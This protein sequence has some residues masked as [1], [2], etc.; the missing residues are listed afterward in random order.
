MVQTRR[1]VRKIMSINNL[2]ST[3]HT[4]SSG[5]CSSVGIATGYGLHGPGIESWWGRDFPNMFRPALGPAQ[6]TLQWA[7]GL[8]RG[9]RS[10]LG[11][12]LTPHHL[13]VPWSRKSIVIPLLPLWA[14]RPVQS[15]SA[16]KR[17]HFTFLIKVKQS[18]YRPGVAQRIPGS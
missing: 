14:V 8:S 3:F 12:I 16:Y 13:L 7:P 11:V 9:V 18:H 2:I 1:L 15:L 6:P 4:V 5:P 10:G 17:E